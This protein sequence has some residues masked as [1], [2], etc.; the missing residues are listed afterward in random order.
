M[1]TFTNFQLLKILREPKKRKTM[2]KLTEKSSFLKLNPPIGGM[3]SK[4]NE[5]FFEY[6]HIS[7]FD[8]KGLRHAPGEYCKIYC[9]Y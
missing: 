6:T 5:I 1:Q 9:T 7:C 8:G 4:D 3:I 2:S